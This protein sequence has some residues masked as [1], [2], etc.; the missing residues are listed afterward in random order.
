MSISFDLFCFPLG[1]RVA[2]S[3]AEAAVQHDDRHLAEES[4]GGGGK[5]FVS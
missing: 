3:L 1:F 5:E 2:F 4:Q